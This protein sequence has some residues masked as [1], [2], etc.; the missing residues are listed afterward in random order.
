MRNTI[1]TSALA[2]MILGMA[3]CAV[4]PGDPLRLRGDEI[5]A[6]G[7]FF[8]TGTPV[9]LWLAPS[10]YDAYRCRRHF[11]PDRIMPTTPADKGNPNRYGTRGGLTEDLARGVQRDG[12]TLDNLREVVDQ[13]VIHYDVCGTS[14][15]CFKVLHDL[16]G[17]SVQF[18][19][20]VDGTVYQTL[21]LSERAWHAG[22][23]NDRSIGIEI[24]NIGAYPDTKTLD[25]WYDLDQASWPYVTFPDWMTETGIRTPDFIARPARKDLIRGRVHG[26]DL[27]QY[28]F[29]DEQYEAL[30]KLTAALTRIFPRLKL[31]MPR[32]PEGNLRMDVLS[33][34]ELDEYA[35]LLAHWHITEGK[36]DPGPA[37]DWERVLCGARKE[38]GPW[39]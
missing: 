22:S 29:T 33:D 8:H 20:D 2:I 7:R 23:A 1:S 18:M 37:F 16:R 38:L 13:F 11:E 4:T 3:G 28:D 12:W 10:G 39:N 25:E 6:G 31:D 14:R 27:M 32:G 9:V 5:V 19:L 15:Q 34:G 30:I 21:D 24:A 35:G 17:L 36:I 26:R